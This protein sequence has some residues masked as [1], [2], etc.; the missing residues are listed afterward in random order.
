MAKKYPIDEVRDHIEHVKELETEIDRLKDQVNEYQRLI[1]EAL[2]EFP[3]K[4][5]L[6]LTI[7]IKEILEKAL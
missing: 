5:E 3:P 2:D 4:L 7:R 6:P 1:K